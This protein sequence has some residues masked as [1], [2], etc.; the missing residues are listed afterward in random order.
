MPGKIL[1]VEDDRAVSQS[2]TRLLAREDY[3]IAVRE[4]GEDALALLREDPAYDLVLLD[5]GLPGQDGYACCRALRAVGWRQPVLMLTGR[6]TATDKV[7]GLEAGAD[8]YI[9]KPFDPAEL[10]AR[11]R[12]H[13]R[14]ARDYSAPEAQSHHIS[15]GPNLRLDLHARDAYVRDAPA[16]LTDREYELLLLLARHP[17]E[18]LDKTW[19]FQEI[20]G[21][22]PELGIK[23]LA[24]YVRRLRQK[25]EDDPDA[26]RY[27]QTARGHGYKLVPIEAAAAEAS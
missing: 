24:V 17:G 8:D 20:W 3:Y 2:L 19:L 23:V 13:L 15:L 1:L 12:A 4:S 27:I 10:L 22:A 9:A 25:I 7:V 5:V 6:A 21:C 14:R 16:R 26:P 18:A 11:V